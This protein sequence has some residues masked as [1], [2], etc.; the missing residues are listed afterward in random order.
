MIEWADKTV[1]NIN[2]DDLIPYDRNPKTHPDT[3]IT[4]I[5]NSIREWGW[6]IPILIDENS[7]VIAGHGRLYAAKQLG[8]ETV[9]C[10]RAEG[11]T[12]EQKKAYVI[13]DNKIAENGEWDTN[14]YF[15]QLKE[16]SNDGYDL[17]LMGI[18]ID[19]SAFSYNPEY[20]PSFDASEV[21]ES[22]MLKAENQ[23]EKD[24]QERLK[25]KNEIDVI[26]PHCGEEFSFS[27]T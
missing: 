16:M 10:L 23:L 22:K 9:P 25:E 7:Q 15:L 21:D 18:D 19:L 6:T 13:A 20:N 1:E 5:A 24:Q 27:G 14:E 11:W 8:R 17:S 4:Q 2:V 26:C 12:D 3:Q